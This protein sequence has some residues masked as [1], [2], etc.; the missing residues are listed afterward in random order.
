MS[1]YISNTISSILTNGIQLELESEEEEQYYIMKLQEYFTSETQFPAY[2]RSKNVIEIENSD[3]QIAM[4]IVIQQST[5]YL[6]PYSQEVFEIFT[7]V[8][9]FIANNHKDIMREFRGD[10]E[11]KIESLDDIGNLEEEIK[12]IM[13]LKRCINLE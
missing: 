1:G 5:L 10:E 4:E 13:N 9:K 6:L 8:L 7:E 3:M 12:L 11:N 2:L